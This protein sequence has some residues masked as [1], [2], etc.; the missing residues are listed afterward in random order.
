MDFERILAPV[1]KPKGTKIA[2]NGSQFADQIG[3]NRAPYGELDSWNGSVRRTLKMIKKNGFDSPLLTTKIHQKMVQKSTKIDQ[4]WC[5]EFHRFFDAI[6][7]PKDIPKIIENPY[8]N[9]SK[10]QYFFH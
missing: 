6:W 1:G 7:L 4:K 5:P 10:N 2:Q 8:K 3:P 9:Q